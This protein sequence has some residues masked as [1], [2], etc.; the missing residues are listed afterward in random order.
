MH[1]LR[2]WPS[3]AGISPQSHYGDAEDGR[4]GAL[5]CL[6]DVTIYIYIYVVLLLPFFV[7]LV[8]ISYYLNNFVSLLIKFF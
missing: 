1:E 5:D 7:L 3:I 2:H 8:S 4:I 6:H